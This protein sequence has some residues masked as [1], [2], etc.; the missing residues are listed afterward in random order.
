MPSLPCHPV[1]AI[2]AFKLN[3]VGMRKFSKYETAINSSTCCLVVL[4]VSQRADS[5]STCAQDGKTT[6]SIAEHC[7]FPA[8]VALIKAIGSSKS[9]ITGEASPEFRV[10]NPN[11]DFVLLPYEP[12]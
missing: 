5:I 2:R 7:R 12:Y 11:H 9:T 8:V 4:D 1:V 3:L 6:V 10:Q